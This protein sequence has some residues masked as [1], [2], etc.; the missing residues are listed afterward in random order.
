MTLSRAG[1]VNNCKTSLLS[2]LDHFCP[3]RSNCVFRRILLFVDEN[4][5]E[6]MVAL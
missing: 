1:I 2:G 3:F 5:D 6:L 4:E